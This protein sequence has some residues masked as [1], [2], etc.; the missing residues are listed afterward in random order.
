[1]SNNFSKAFSALELVIVLAIVSLLISVILSASSI[2]KNAYSNSLLQEVNKIQSAVLTFRNKYN[3]LPGDISDG[4]VLF[5]DDCGTESECDGN[6]D[7]YIALDSISESDEY[8]SSFIHLSLAGI[9]DSTYDRT[10][11]QYELKSKGLASIK[12]V[13]VSDNYQ[14]NNNAITALSLNDDYLF[15]EPYRLMLIDNKVDDG[16]PESGFVTYY[17]DGASGC[18][19][20]SEYVEDD[21]S[22]LCAAIF[23]LSE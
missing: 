13:S 14:I 10:D 16:H 21:E 3:G 6:A 18:V 20:D 17:T 8:V 12:Y 7:G 11:Y 9:L 5:G 22:K 2:K 19:S 23:K 4:Y 15:I 1:M